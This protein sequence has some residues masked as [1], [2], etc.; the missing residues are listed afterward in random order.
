MP[1]VPRLVPVP[2]TPG[3]EVPVHETPFWIGSSRD[4][5]LPVF[6]PG[7]EPR[8][9]AVVERED[10][11]WATPVRAVA[12]PPELNGAALRDPARLRHGDV[13][14]VAPGAAYR[15][16][17]PPPAAR[18]SAPREAVPPPPPPVPPPPRVKKAKKARRKIGVRWTH[19]AFAL[20]ILLLLGA[21]AVFVQALRRPATVQPLSEADAREYDRLVAVSYE[22]V[23]RGATLLELGIPDEAL[24]EFA[25]AVRVLETSRLRDNPWVRPQIATLERTV[26]AVYREKRVAVPPTFRDAPSAPAAPPARPAL[27]SQLSATEFASRFESVQERFQARYGRRIFVTG[28]DHAEHLSLYGTGGALDLRV[29]DLSREQID[30]AIQALRAEGIRV[31]D[32]STDQVLRAQVASARRAGLHDRAST[33]LHL[34]IDRFISRRDRWTVQ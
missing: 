14:R 8:H 3:A 11:F 18:P 22:H 1:T 26:A 10:G 5:A 9:V 27:G 30:F 17:D 6:L 2:P 33:G 13:L 7:V 15:F 12:A 24:R 16:E 19:V 31:K 21:A 23:E 25:R 32:F 4:S 20:S 29:R 34:H 28:K